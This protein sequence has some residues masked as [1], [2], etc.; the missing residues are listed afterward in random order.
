M[1]QKNQGLIGGFWKAEGSI[2][3]RGQLQKRIGIFYEQDACFFILI[4][5]SPPHPFLFL[6]LSCYPIAVDIKKNTAALYG[7][8][9]IKTG[10]HHPFFLVYLI[11]TGR[12]PGRKLS[13]ISSHPLQK[14][15]KAAPA[16]LSSPSLSSPIML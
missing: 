11:K 8:Y 7:V 15:D 10:Q 1:K 16:N 13:P 3:E 6:V 4:S 2:M 5:S 9:L 14:S 12:P